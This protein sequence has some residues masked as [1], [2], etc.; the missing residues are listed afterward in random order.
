MTTA[1]FKESNNLVTGKQGDKDHCLPL[2]DRRPST[3]LYLT[4][5]AQ[6]QR[7]L[8]FAVAHCQGLSV[9]LSVPLP[10]PQPICFLKAPPTSYTN[11]HPSKGYHLSPQ[12][13][14]PNKK[15]HG[16]K[17][18]SGALNLLNKPQCVYSDCELTF[19]SQFLV[20]SYTHTASKH[21][22][23][24]PCQYSHQTEQN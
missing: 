3:V 15:R 17:S 16:S 5:K 14:T 7:H 13:S 10:P 19:H 22:N 20:V 4:T 23:R 9:N 18:V 11:L 2:Y 8:L 21:Y 12:G 1:E 6:L 24:F